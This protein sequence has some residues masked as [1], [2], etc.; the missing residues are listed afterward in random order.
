M[1]LWTT[2]ILAL[3]LT[4]IA[5]T[6]S[7]EEAPNCRN[8]IFVEEG[9]AYGLA[10]VTGGDRLS[11]IEDAYYCD[12]EKQK[13]PCPIC[14]SEDAACRSKSYLIPG[15]LVITARSFKGYRCIL[16]RNEKDFAGSA[17]YVPENRLEALPAATVTQK[18][19]LGEW[20]MGD[21]SITLRA[22]GAK[23]AASGVAYWPSANP[24]PKE[25]PGGPHMGQMSGVAAPMG[26]RIA[27]A[28]AEDECHVSLTLLPPFLL[29]RDDNRCGG[30]NVRFDGVYLRAGKSRKR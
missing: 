12:K 21:D 7:A 19:W 22:R 20:R 14:P 30:M 17:G 15:D 10:R 1:K 8:G 26:D 9:V 6:A 18:D 25:V 23:L 5:T 3:F 13:A 2:F 16:Y 24:S 27:F 11:F 28:D 29:A 4:V